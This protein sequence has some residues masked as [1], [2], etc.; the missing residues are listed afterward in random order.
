MRTKLG[1]PKG[2]MLWQTW[3]SL[4]YFFRKKKIIQEYHPDRLKTSSGW[5]EKGPRTWR[6]LQRKIRR[7]V[8]ERLHA[9]KCEIHK[10]RRWQNFD[11]ISVGRRWS[12][13][14]CW[15][16]KVLNHSRQKTRVHLIRA[17]IPCFTT[18]GIR[19]SIGNRYQFFQTLAEPITSTL[20]RFFV[21]SCWPCEMNWKVLMNFYWIAQRNW[22]ICLN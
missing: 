10:Q 12:V 20:V 3:V 5:E 16:S 8:G 7:L 6:F 17:R 18:G 2:G 19:T 13:S 22:T 1:I 21:G 9:G 15:K 11:D 14:T 4:P